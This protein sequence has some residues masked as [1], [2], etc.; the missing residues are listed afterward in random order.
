M[1]VSEGYRNVQNLSNEAAVVFEPL[2]V[3]GL[4]CSPKFE[5]IPQYALDMTGLA[6]FMFDTLQL[7]SKSNGIS[8]GYLVLGTSILQLAFGR[9][10]HRFQFKKLMFQNCTV[11]IRLSDVVPNDAIVF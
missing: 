11:T 3:I 1:R 8:I 10:A 4:R 5:V 9:L 7:L 6:K 2:L